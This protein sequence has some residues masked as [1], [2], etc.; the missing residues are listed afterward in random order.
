MALTDNLDAWWKFDEG[1]GSSVADATGHGYD[2]TLNGSPTWDSSGLIGEAVKYSGSGQNAQGPTGQLS[3]VGASALTISAWVRADGVNGYPAKPFVRWDSGS[4]SPFLLALRT[5]STSGFTA[6]IQTAAGAKNVT[7]TGAAPT[8]GQWYH[9]VVVFDGTSVVIYRDGTAFSGS[10]FAATTISK[11]IYGSQSLI[12]GANAATGAS[13]TCS[14]DEV[15]IWSRALSAGE[16]AEL[17]NSGA[18]KTYPFSAGGGSGVIGD[19]DATETGADTAT[20]TGDVPVSGAIAAAE[21]VADTASATGAVLA[22]GSFAAAESGSDIA[23]GTGSVAWPGR[24]GSLSA[25]E[26][27]VDSFAGSSTVAISGAF[28]VSETGVDAFAASGAAAWPDGTGTLNATEA[29]ADVAVASGTIHVAGAFAIGE[30]GADIA[31][32]AGDVPVAGQLAAA[33]SGSDIAA[34][35]GA[36]AIA[37][38]FV[39]VE[40]GADTFA[41]SGSVRPY[42]S[43]ALVAVETGPDVAALA[44]TVLVIGSLDALAAGNDN[45]AIVVSVLVSGALSVSEHGFDGFASSGVVIVPSA[46]APG[47]ILSVVAQNRV[48]F[49]V[50]ASRT[51]KA[52]KM[53]RRVAA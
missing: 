29:G 22:T 38:A 23:A 36:V 44:G 5:D 33:E 18:G 32:F 24:V 14:V 41:G 9:I 37:G 53:N 35:L 10:S 31:A 34:L 13:T 1:S 52:T 42:G 39:G 49:A 51:T 47:R 17:Y 46:T 30:A 8:I 20:L 3:Y 15:G 40:T 27:G 16:V 26:T 48:A 7:A 4:T 19:L 28:A 12:M 21:T 45:A 11:T 25:G 43:G 50:S 6:T 2:L